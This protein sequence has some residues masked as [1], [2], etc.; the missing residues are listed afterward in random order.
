MPLHLM[1]QCI[2]CVSCVVNKTVSKLPDHIFFFPIS[3]F[4]CGK[5]IEKIT[6]Q[7]INAKMSEFIH[8]PSYKWCLHIAQKI[9]FNLLITSLRSKVCYIKLS[10]EAGSIG[11]VSWPTSSRFQLVAFWDCSIVT[12]PGGL[13]K[14]T[15][16]LLSGA[17][18]LSVGS[19]LWLES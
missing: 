18:A 19:K 11:L 6:C 4:N 8:S 1:T 9:F 5:S 3:D 14:M 17:V 7:K 12:P 15:C 2:I 16:W 10:V 13:K